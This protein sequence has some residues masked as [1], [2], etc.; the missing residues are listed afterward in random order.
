MA[1]RAYDFNKSFSAFTEKYISM[2]FS[3]AWRKMSKH[4]TRECKKSKSL[5]IRGEMGVPVWYDERSR[6]EKQKEFEQKR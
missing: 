3:I 5:N 6:T 2:N 4:K 1:I